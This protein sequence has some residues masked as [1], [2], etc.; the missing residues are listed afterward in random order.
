MRH[1]LTLVLG[2]MLATSHAHALARPR[3]RVEAAIRYVNPRA[4]RANV[5]HWASVIRAEAIARHFD[6]FTLVAIVRFESGFSP[7]AVN[8]NPP[9]EYSVG[10]S[11]INVLAMRPACRELPLL[12][13]S[14]CQA[15]IARLMD[16]AYNLR[17]AARLISGFRDHCRKRT[18]KPALFARWLSAFQGY[19]QR[20]G[21]TCNMRKD[22]RGRWRD[23][24]VPTLT[25]RVMRYRIELIKSTA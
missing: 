7:G 18:G 9:R 25:R 19:D 2:L 21:V 11:Q 4:T 12:S 15:S 14:S 1:T 24:P 16:G 20:P 17:V 22:R 3:S 8:N 10:L 5:R 23:L 13:S 6:P